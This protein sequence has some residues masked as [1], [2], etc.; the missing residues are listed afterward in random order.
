MDKLNIEETIHGNNKYL[1]LMCKNDEIIQYQIKM[2]NNNKELSFIEIEDMNINDDIYMNYN[3]TKYCN[4]Y[5]CI[6]DMTLSIKDIKNILYKLIS[7]L[8]ELDSYLLNRNNIIFD[9]KRVFFNTDNNELKL[10]YVPLKN[11]LSESKIDEKVC[12]LNLL[13]AYK[14]IIGNNEELER[15]IIEVREENGDLISLKNHLDKIEDNINI[16]ETTVLEEKEEEDVVVKKKR[17]WNFKREKNIIQEEH[18]ESVKIWTIICEDG[19]LISLDKDTYILGRLKSDVDIQLKDN[20]VGRI[21]GKIERENDKYYY[22]DLNSR[23]G[24]YLNKERLI[25][26]KRYLLSNGD[27]LRLANIK[28]IISVNDR[29][30]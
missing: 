3:I 22:I 11:G 25:P 5:E 18:I 15:A 7:V 17:F 4:M 23:N 27:E 14:N 24:S 28:M 30:M 8:T 16:K 13:F 20:S 29:G 1:Q 26:E 10:I 21:H 2:I 12:I 6:N 19:S 9:M